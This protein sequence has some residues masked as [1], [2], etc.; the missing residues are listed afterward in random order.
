MLSKQF[1]I[2]TSARKKY[3]LLNKLLVRKLKNSL[4]FV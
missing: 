2:K 1:N 3:D 4:S